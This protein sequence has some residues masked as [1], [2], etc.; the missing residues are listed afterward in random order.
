MRIHYDDIKRQLEDGDRRLR[1]DIKITEETFTM[2]VEQKDNEIAMLIK[3]NKEL[4]IYNETRLQSDKMKYDSLLAEFDLLKRENQQIKELA[5]TRTR[6]ID[7]WSKRF[8]GYVTEDEAGNMRDELN[9][10]RRH[11]ME[12]E[13]LNTQQRLDTARMHEKD[14]S[15]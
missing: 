13:E 6:Q 12:L 15:F 4:I 9:R 2:T 14:R 7:E 1:E 11:N 10:L 5:E 3:Q 8:K